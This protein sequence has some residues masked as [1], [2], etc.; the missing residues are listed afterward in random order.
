MKT[1][2]RIALEL[3]WFALE[4]FTYASLWVGNMASMIREIA[5]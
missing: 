2:V 1:I 5:I 3:F 4:Q